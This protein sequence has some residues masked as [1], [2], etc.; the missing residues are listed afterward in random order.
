V[1][2]EQ[3]ERAR[4]A[5]L[6]SYGLLDTPNEP[7]FD[8]IVLETKQAL[9]MPIVLISLV[10]ANRQWFKAKVGIEATQIP[11][12]IS[13]CTHAIKGRDVLIIPD[14]KLDERFADN[15]LVTHYPQ[16]RFY[17]GTPLI[18]GNDKRIGT[19][20]VLDTRPRRDFNTSAAAILTANAAATMAAVEKRARL[21][22]NQAA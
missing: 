13:F 18:A 7:A 21:L 4:V 14:A 5:A 11:L 22:G 2:A 10:D 9:S 1:D 17:A 8:R 12:S 19:L 16:V 6:R 20:C 15:P 3:E